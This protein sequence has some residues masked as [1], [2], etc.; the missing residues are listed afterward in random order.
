MWYAPWLLYASSL[1]V[2]LDAMQIL[3]FCSPHVFFSRY[4]DYFPWPLLFTILFQ[5]GEVV[6][7]YIQNPNWNTTVV[8]GIVQRALAKSGP[9][10]A[11]LHGSHISIISV[12][13]KSTAACGFQP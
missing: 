13:R 11:L 5:V 10:V 8:P 3:Y 4:K 2:S 7:F 9:A 12:S 1:L 6:N